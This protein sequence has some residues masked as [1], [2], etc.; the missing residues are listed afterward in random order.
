MCTVVVMKTGLKGV[1]VR[2]WVARC[3]FIIVHKNLPE[4]MRLT[5]DCQPFEPHRYWRDK[6]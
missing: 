2:P 3:P 6:A 5:C 1:Q 4:G